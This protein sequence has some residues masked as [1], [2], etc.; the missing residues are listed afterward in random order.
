MAD[1]EWA[2]YEDV[3]VFLLNRFAEYFGLGRVEGKTIVP[4]AGTAWEL[5]GIGYSQDGA[6][7]VIVEC[8]RYTTSRV[9]QDTMGVLAFR[10]LR[11][12]A[13]GGIIVTPIGYQAGAAKVANFEGITRVTLNQDC[14]TVEYVMRFL[15]QVQVGLTDTITATDSVSITLFKAD[16]TVENYGPY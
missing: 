14:T 13:S 15:D 5:D 4:A 12:G 9:N 10:I 11:T 7:F 2:T 6:Q 8:K 1:K 16:G 3:A